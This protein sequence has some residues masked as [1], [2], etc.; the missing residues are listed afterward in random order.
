MVAPSFYTPSSH[1]CHLT[2]NHLTRTTLPAHQFGCHILLIQFLQLIY[3][4]LRRPTLTSH[5]RIDPSTIVHATVLEGVIQERQLDEVKDVKEDFVDVLIET[6][7]DRS[8]DSSIDLDSIK[9]L[10][11]DVFV[12]GTDTISSSTEWV[13]SELLR[14]P[15]VMEKL[16]SE[17]RGIVKQNQHIK[18]D[19]LE[20]MGYMKAVIKETLRLHPPFPIITRVTRKDVQIKGYDVA[21][22]TMVMINA[23]ALGRDPVSWDEPE[24]IRP[25][26][27]LNSSI[28]L[29]GQDFELI[30]FEAGRRGCPGITYATVT[31]EILLANLVHKFDWKLPNGI[32]LDMTESHG[33]TVHRASPL[34]ALASQPK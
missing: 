30:P 11:L 2:L 6:Y 5:V 10:L 27:F 12:G 21:S 26:R 34:L 32:D 25:D 29:K 33:V 7:N 8:V 13:M 18:P 20:N 22:G 16:Q 28:D 17:V 23:W 15:R 4:A 14:H 31:M 19:D 24:Q 9:A 1:A 3:Y